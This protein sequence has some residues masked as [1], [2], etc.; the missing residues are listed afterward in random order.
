MKKRLTRIGPLKAGIV[1]SI[2]YGVLGLLLAPFMLLMA[3]L[4]KGAGA[5]GAVVGVVFAIFIP[6]LY[7]VIGF[8][9]GVICAAVYNLIA[10]WTGGLEFE[11]ADIPEPGYYTQPPVS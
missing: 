11:I 1:L 9:G 6:V 4:G 2:L 5:K 3:M 10:K 8:V 7:A